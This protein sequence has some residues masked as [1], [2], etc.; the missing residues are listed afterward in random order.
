MLRSK[1]DA[2][3]T[4]VCISEMLRHLRNSYLRICVVY[5][6]GLLIDFYRGDASSLGE[7]MSEAPAA[8]T[9]LAYLS[10]RSA[11]T[12]QFTSFESQEEPS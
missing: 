6:N 11:A 1:R 9:F 7:A 4:L 5:S 2:Y 3:L 12:F 10:F 8:C